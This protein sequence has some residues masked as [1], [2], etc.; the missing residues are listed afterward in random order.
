MMVPVA[1]IS[2]SVVVITGASSGI[3]LAA[4]QRF[5]RRDARL[6]LAARAAEPLE[7]AAQQCIGL[8]AEAIAIP[9][10]VTDDAAVR[11]LADRA[12]AAFG[13]LDVWVNSAGVMVYGAFEDVPADVFRRVIETNLFGQVH[14]TRAALP[15]FRRQ[16]TGVLINMSSVWGRVTTPDVSAYVTSKFG[17]RAFSECVR[18]E[19]RDAPG[20]AVSVMLPAAVDT[21]IFRAAGNFAGRRVRPVPPV[22]DPD[23]IAAGIE[24]CAEN[25]AREI[26]YGRLAR[27]LEL[28]HSLAPG[29]YNRFAPGAFAAGN[30]ADGAA[31]REPGNVLSPA[32]GPRA[33]SG[34][35][36]AR[37]RRELLTALA[38]AAGGAVGGLVRGR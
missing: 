4:A 23:V 29:L 31:A 8:G 20:I 24:A 26:T 1:A 7:A 10:D 18:Q 30:F 21:P 34:G 14:G 13:R 33:V 12:V 15:H 28:V 27:V 38:A 3:G 25:P 36:R 35:W 17:V 16:G 37:H 9:T 32:P 22:I 6:V 5:A 2:G 11:A 19:L